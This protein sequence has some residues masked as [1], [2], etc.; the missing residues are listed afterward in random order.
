VVGVPRVVGGLAAVLNGFVMPAGD[1]VLV[2][3]V[4]LVGV[5]VV[6]ESAGATAVS[7]GEPPQ[8]VSVRPPMESPMMVARITPVRLFT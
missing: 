5:V 6:A 3:V 4:V 7:V 1:S 8:P 2:V